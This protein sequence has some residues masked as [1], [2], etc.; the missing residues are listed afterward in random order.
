LIVELRRRVLVAAVLAWMALITF[1]DLLTMSPGSV[2]YVESI[3]RIPFV[4]ARDWFHGLMSAPF[5]AP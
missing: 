2:P 5:H 3:T 4:A 1:L